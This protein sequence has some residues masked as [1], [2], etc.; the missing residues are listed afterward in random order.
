MNR[1]DRL[2]ATILLLQGRRLITA[3]DIAAHFEISPRTVYRDI[4]ALSEGGVPIVA[5]A[6]VGYS[7]LNGYSMPPVMFTPDEAA[8]LFMGGEFVDHLTDPSLRGQMRSALLK[9]RSVLPRAQQDHLDRLKRTTA[10]L[11]TRPAPEADQAVLTR[12]QTA[13]AQ[14]RVLEL[15]YQTKGAGP[16]VRREVEPLGLIYYSDRWHLIGY[17]R[18]RGDFRDFRTDRIQKLSLRDEV[19]QGHPDF[20]LQEH[21]RAWHEERPR[22]EMVFR[23]GPAVTDRFRN[24]WMGAIL[25]ERKHGDRTVFT[26]LCDPCD[27]LANWLLS[28]GTELEVISPDALRATMAEKALVIARH[29]GAGEEAASPLESTGVSAL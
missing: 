15:H 2:M 26:V 12:I 21:I 6:G 7:L 17:C 8:A 14:R 20:S 3:E 23:T 22:Q 18:L 28:F 1:I 5:E 25:N 4:A 29:H 24:S 27:W 9:I 13:L 16:A 11:V 19:F 10:L